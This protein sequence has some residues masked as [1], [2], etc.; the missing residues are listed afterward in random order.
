MKTKLILKLA[1]SFLVSVIALT[2]ISA[3]ILEFVGSDINPL[4]FA[5]TASSALTIAVVGLSF[6][7]FKSV[8]N[9]AMA[10]LL[11]EAW[12]ATIA[13]NLYQNSDFMKYATDHSM[14]ISNKVVHLPQ[15]GGK[16]GVQQ[17]R[18]IIPATI[19]SRL[20]TDSTYNLN[21]YTVDPIVIQYTE[22]VQISYPKRLS[23]LSNFI[24]QLE[25]VIATQTLY[26]WAPSGAARIVST[27]GVGSALNLPHSTAT[28]TR[29]QL[30]LSDLA[31]AK[32]KLDNDYVPNTDRYLLIPSYMYNTDLLGISNIAQA[33]AFGKPVLPDGVVAQV[34]GFNILVRPDVLVYDNSGTPLIK[35]INGDGSLTVAAT[36]DQGAA[37][38]FHKSVISVAKGGV[39]SFFRP[40]NPEYY[41]DIFSA[42]VLH[43]ASLL[44]SD[45]KGI[46]AI[47]QG[48]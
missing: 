26:A 21:E 13:E 2:F 34:M 14:W 8:K 20:D 9:A 30:T 41:G 12:S 32:Q 48:T 42:L 29:K 25:F 27:T 36:T 38:A 5:L 1:L 33:Y 45:Q 4:K 7:G 11:T 3:P 31:A 24:S 22:E 10:G 40:N 6:A 47:V 37:L 39:Q 46:V 35:A 44:R 19:G 43:G 17:N 15:A 16:P 28:G 23:I 18:T